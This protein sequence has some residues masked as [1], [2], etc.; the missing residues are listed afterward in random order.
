MGKTKIKLFINGSI[1]ILLVLLVGYFVYVD[2]IGSALLAI[3]TLFIITG[4]SMRM[5][6]LIYPAISGNK[7]Y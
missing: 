1:L 5:L 4:F 6:F 3:L 7:N 2:T